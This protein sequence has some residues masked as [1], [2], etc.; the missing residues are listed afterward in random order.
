VRRDRRLPLAAF[1][2]SAVV[3]ERGEGRYTSRMSNDAPPLLAEAIRLWEQ[4]QSRQMRR[5]LPEAIRLYRESLATY[6]TAEAHTFLGWALSWQG[7]VDGAIAECK[8]A[9]GVDPEFGNPYNDIG[10]YLIEKGRFEE[11]IPWLEQ[12]QRAK[13]YDPRHYPHLNL[14]RIYAQTGK[15]SRAISEFE[16]ALALHPGDAMAREALSKLRTLN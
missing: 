4:G 12:A 7:D 16:Q 1:S 11:A 5:D 9:I 13:R 14:G 15:V 6:P 3:A 2:G 8:L 10:V